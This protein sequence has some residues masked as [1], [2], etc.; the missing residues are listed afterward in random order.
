[1]AV[2]NAHLKPATK[3]IARNIR[4]AIVVA[5]FN[6][7]I[8][9]A[10]VEQN[11]ATLKEEWFVHIDIFKVP[12]VFEVPAM[13]SLI[14]DKGIYNV[15]ITLGCVI[16]GSTPHFDYVCNACTDGITELM[17]HYDT[18]IIFGI[19]TCDTLEQAQAR[20]N[21]NYAIYAMN[22]ITQW[23]EAETLLTKRYEELM[24]QTKEILQNN[25]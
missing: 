21:N 12:G 1:M 8:T 22:Y 23:S 18:P 15:V 2:H 25:P 5:E 17:T 13:T 16:R 24:R 9:G 10:L 11:I 19:L 14:L 6:E 7:E 4:I 20:V 3:D